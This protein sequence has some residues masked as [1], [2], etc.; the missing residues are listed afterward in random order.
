MNRTE[1]ESESVPKPRPVAAAGGDTT[2]G[3][4][5]FAEVAP[6]AS[7]HFVLGLYAAVFALIHHVRRMAELGGAPLDQVLDRYGFLHRYLD[8]MRTEMPDGLI[9]ADGSEWWR[10]AI[11]DW[12]AR[13]PD[14]LP[15]AALDRAVGIGFAGRLAFLLVG[16]VEEDSR[17]GTLFAELQEPL[18]HRRPTLELVG[19]IL[20]DRPVAGASD[21]WSLC[22]P[23]LAA[24]FLEAPNR[25]APRSEWLLRVPP[26]IWDA[27]RGAVDEQPLPGCRYRPRTSLTPVADLLH[28]ANLLERLERLPALV[29]AGRVAS[30][31]LRGDSGSDRAEVLGA[32]ARALDRG[33][34]VVGDA[35]AASAQTWRQLA[36]LA[37]LS[38]SL[39]GLGYELGPGEIADPPRLPAYDDPIGLLLGLEGGLAGWAAERAVSLTLA[40]PRAAL[41][42]R[43]WLRALDGRPVD[44]LP[45]IA[46]R[47]QLSGGY[48]VR[49]AEMAGAQ[50]GLGGR[51][52]VCPDDVREAGR[53]LNRQLL[54]TLAHRL[55]ARGTW[56][57][58]VACPSTRDKLF[59][60]GQR[61]RYRERLLDHLAPALGAGA[62]RGVRAL[63]TGPSGT[64]KTLAARILA[65]ELGMDVYRVDLAAV[66]NKYIGETEKNLHRV[67]SRA[68]ALDVV[69]LLDEGDALLGQR[70]EV[71]SANDRYANLE[72]N[73]LLQRLELYQGIALVTTNLGENIDPA[74]QR[75]MDVVVP[76]F[77][78]QAA[79]RWRI[80]LL[81]LGAGH[82]VDE[83]FLE[84]VAVRCALTGGQ[85]RNAAL[86]AS[87]LALDEA[88][89]IGRRHLER[90]LQSEYRKAGGLYPLT[91]PEGNGSRDAGFGS[92]LAALH[93][94]SGEA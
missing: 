43:W 24:G 65:A 5:C 30:L 17:F 91:E 29:E 11:T 84:R 45:E 92:L 36:P 87:L 52:T 61:C 10:R 81:H 73:Y 39:V 54:D 90:G 3:S 51:R 19:Q 50:A 22:R 25:E 40:P 49:L 14:P 31:V 8:E 94:A 76:F 60:L 77:P 72:T 6:D 2:P 35:A 13:T 18:A 74:F 32:V 78:P 67:L 4:G 55:E 56:D 71:K 12:E 79:E 89:P 1:T 93:S 83:G 33:L 57:D 46:T 85:I 48:I 21:P 82:T 70:T 27:A 34:L 26:A 64:G 44:G 38:R 86:H 16:L 58:L 28:P 66:V 88:A 59:E 75:R 53:T 80:L 37:V 69:L 23:L 68:E 42:E 63:L 20:V 41:R 9:W 7:G 47:F 15:L 62:N